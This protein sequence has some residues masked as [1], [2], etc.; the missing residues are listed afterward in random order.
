MINVV[1]THTVLYSSLC[2]IVKS[3]NNT[4]WQTGRGT[5]TWTLLVMLFSLFAASMAASVC[6]GNLNDAWLRTKT[7]LTSGLATR[8]LERTL[9]CWCCPRQLRHHSPP[10]VQMYSLIL[11]WYFLP[12]G[13]F[14]SWVWSWTGTAYMDNTH[15]I[16]RWGLWLSPWIKLYNDGMKALLR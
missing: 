16:N 10:G 5:A 3:A 6:L 7:Y 2:I 13:Q 8:R 12:K 15:V 9:F 4:V 14:V 1:S 11:L